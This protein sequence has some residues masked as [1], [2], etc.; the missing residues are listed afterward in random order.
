MDGLIS[1]T[2]RWMFGWMEIRWMNRE[3]RRGV[4]RWIARLMYEG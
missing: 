3:I 2:G 1:S 4:D